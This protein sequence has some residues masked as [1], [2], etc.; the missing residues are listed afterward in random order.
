M[1]AT[2]ILLGLSEIAAAFTGFSGI[3][4]ALGNT[5]TWSEIA[6][7]RFQNLLGISIATVV[8]SLLPILVSSYEIDDFLKWRIVCFVLATFVVGFLVLRA[9]IARRLTQ[10]NASDRALRTTGLAFATI[11][12][13]V[14]LLQVLSVVGIFSLGF[15]FYLTGLLALL[16]LSALQFALLALAVLRSG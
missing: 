13:I 6:R 1:E 14:L 15:A 10:E 12:P 8:L 5:S 11:L 9:P 2:D 4:A 3:V 16:F 7:F